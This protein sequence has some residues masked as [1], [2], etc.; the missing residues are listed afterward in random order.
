M[1]DVL[2]GGEQILEFTKDYLYF[3]PQDLKEKPL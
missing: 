2:I 1:R 3:Y